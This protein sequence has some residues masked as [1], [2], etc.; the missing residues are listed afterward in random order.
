MIHI[1]KRSFLLSALLLGTLTYARA[2][3]IKGRVLDTQNQPVKNADV[4]V[5]PFGGKLTN[6]PFY[7]LHADSAGRFQA[8]MEPG[9]AGSFGR[10]YATAPGM[11]PISIFLSKDSAQKENLLHLEPAATV[12]GRIIDSAGKAVSDVVVQLQSLRYGKD[13]G[14][15]FL[16]NTLWMKRFQTVTDK[17]GKWTLQ[18]VP[19]GVTAGILINDPRFVQ[20]NVSTTTNS[21][22]PTTEVRPGAIFTGRVVARNGKP[23]AG[24][25]VLAQGQDGTGGGTETKTTAD[26]SYQLTGLANGTYNIMVFVADKSQV[27]E[28]I[29]GQTAHEGETTKLPDMKLISGGIISGQVL[30]KKTGKPIPR[31]DIASYGKQNPRSSA[32][33]VS[34]LTDETGHYWIRVVPG[35]NYVY[36][37]GASGYIQDANYGYDVTVEEGQTVTQNFEL[38][39]GESLAGILVD[40]DG[41]PIRGAQVLVEPAGIDSLDMDMGLGAVTD[42]RGHWKMSGLKSGA[43]TIRAVDPWR[44]L[45]PVQ[46]T[47]PHTGEI[48]VTA[49]NINSL[50]PT[51]CVVDISYRPLKNITLQLQYMLPI[52]NDGGAG[53][54]YQSVTSDA[55][56][57]LRFTAPATTQ[58]V[59][60]YTIQNPQYRLIRGSEWNAKT[61]HL[62]DIVLDKLDNVAR[63]KVLSADGKPA[64]NVRVHAA[65]FDDIIAQTNSAGDFE[66]RGLPHQDLTL[67]AISGQTVAKTSGASG[68]LHLK[69]IQHNLPTQKQALDMLENLWRETTY[70]EFPGRLGILSTIAKDDPARALDLLKDKDGAIPASQISGVILVIKNRNV[71]DARKVLSEVKGKVPDQDVYFAIDSLAK[72][73]PTLAL[74][75]G[76]QHVA[77]AT[78]DDDKVQVLCKLAELAAGRDNA[79]AQKYFSQAL[80]IAKTFPAPTEK[81]YSSDESTESPMGRFLFSR[82]QLAAASAKI[83]SDQTHQ[84]MMEI[85][86]Y[87]V[88]THRG[89]RGDYDEMRDILTQELV[90]VGATQEVEYLIAHSTPNLQYMELRSAVTTA[91]DAKDIPTAQKYLDQLLQMYQQKIGTDSPSFTNST[92]TL[93]STIRAMIDAIGPTDSARALKLA[94]LMDDKQQRGK[95]LMLA[96]QYQSRQTALKTYE[97]AYSLLQSQ[98]QGISLLPR[99]AAMIYDLDAA[100][101]KVLLDGLLQSNPNAPQIMLTPGKLQASDLVGALARYKPTVSWLILQNAWA[102][103]VNNPQNQAF[104][105]QQLAEAMSQVDFDQAMSWARSIP[106]KEWGTNKLDPSR[107]Y[108]TQL[109]ILQNVLSPKKRLTYFDLY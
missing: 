84:W 96:G 35:K 97:E 65:G 105:Q 8:D 73:N 50:P 47:L 18:G 30:N 11:A 69:P 71:A 1:A 6:S 52:S 10:F 92:Y 13:I 85:L 20:V 38:D 72:I 7:T 55:N 88:D 29:E 17:E 103:N 86:P 46:T 40:K 31:V 59:L 83:H 74:Q 109:A 102:A 32:A 34:G 42:A 107:K 45:Q 24:I 12:N 57:N 108:D 76:R 67:L 27:A 15:V 21:A 4:M 82:V 14:T 39:P 100:R 78:V 3:V 66:L 98:P 104:D 48:R 41:K 26:G 37:M 89:T 75:W 81:T 36:F 70:K 2:D 68:I 101:G 51:G 95:S 22:P 19:Q 28:G 5:E 87:S 33:A 99:L 93:G 58:S 80:A 53:V 56:G 49:Q 16:S 62:S 90:A 43:V 54:Q 60:I 44:N 63:G 25:M 61:R 64:A 94:R 9:Y 23:A 79:L 77:D 91:L 106:G